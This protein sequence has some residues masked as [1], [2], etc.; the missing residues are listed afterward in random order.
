MTRAVVEDA[1]PDG[2][3]PHVSPE[4]RIEIVAARAERQADIDRCL[5]EHPNAERAAP[6]EADAA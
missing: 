3:N 1:W 4:R 2:I 6:V 5:E